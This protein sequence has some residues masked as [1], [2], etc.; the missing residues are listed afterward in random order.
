MEFFM[1]IIRIVAL[2]CALFYGA[3]SFGMGMEAPL[4]EHI[5]VSPP[6]VTSLQDLPEDVKN[7]ILLTTMKDRGILTPIQDDVVDDQLFSLHATDLLTCASLASSPMRRVNR[8]YNQQLSRYYQNIIQALHDR[9]DHYNHINLII[10]LSHGHTNNE[11]IR[12]IGTIDKMITIAPDNFKIKDNQLSE[13]VESITITPE[14]FAA[15]SIENIARSTEAFAQILNNCGQAI[16]VNIDSEAVSRITKNRLHIEEIDRI[17]KSVHDDASRIA[18]VM[19]L[20][21][22]AA[23]LRANYTLSASTA[24]IVTKSAIAGVSNLVPYIVSTVAIVAINQMLLK[25]FPKFYA[26]LFYSTFSAYGNNKVMPAVVFLSGCGMQA[27]SDLLIKKA[28]VANYQGAML[29]P[30]QPMLIAIENMLRTIAPNNPLIRPL[31][32]INAGQMA[33][34]TSVKD[35]VMG[36]V[37]AKKL[38]ATFVVIPL[39]QTCS[40][41]KFS[42]HSIGRHLLAIPLMKAMCHLRG[43]NLPWFAMPFVYVPASILDRFLVKNGFSFNIA[44]IKRA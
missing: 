33:P 8:E 3:V 15:N 37:S 23:L 20:R 9:S 29:A 27:A 44:K 13:Y 1:K 43:S 4:E 30:L 32:Q 22:Y 21:K 17:C 18:A 10:D 5:P 36:D 2:G 39:L 40:M 34:L 26:T 16:V 12:A 24:A 7:E 38:A 41:A 19:Q 28:N 11:K 14:S 31:Q 35:A 25:H 42:I 6:V